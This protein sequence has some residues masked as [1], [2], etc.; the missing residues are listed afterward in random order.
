MRILLPKQSILS[1]S[2]VKIS[3]DFTC[4]C[5]RRAFGFGH[6]VNRRRIQIPFVDDVIHKFQPYRQHDKQLLFKGSAFN[7]SYQPPP[8]S[9]S[10]PISSIISKFAFNARSMAFVQIPILQNQWKRTNSQSA[11]FVVFRRN[12]RSSP[13][14]A[15]TAP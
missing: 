5:I 13:V 4:Q 7:S 11:I 14:A 15:F 2:F 9:S 6:V 8:S 3:G 12:G 1:S 10:L